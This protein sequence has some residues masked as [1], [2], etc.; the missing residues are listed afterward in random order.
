MT[1]VFISH[2][3]KDR[4][5]V[6]NEIVSVLRTHSLNPWYAAED[7]PTAAIWESEI[8]DAL[9]SSDWFL[10]VLSPEAISSLWVKAEVHWAIE[11][12]P[13]RIVPV[14]FKEC[15]IQ[16]L[17]LLLPRYQCVNYCADLLVA[18]SRLLAV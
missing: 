5:F 4:R 9:R 7:I 16:S 3:S 17:S 1:K 11:N 10:V 18:R 14:M 6:E 2:T 12:R 13:D 15:D 8:L